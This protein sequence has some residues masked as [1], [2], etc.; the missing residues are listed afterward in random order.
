MSE[1]KG[2][3]T[4]IIVESPTKTRTLAR[5]LGKRY[6]LLATRGHV[7]DLPERRLAVNI[8]DNFRPEYEVIPRQK[9]H[10]AK[11][12]E[13]LKGVEHVYLACDPDREGEAICWHVKEV[14]GLDSERSKRIEFNE[15]TM[16]AVQQALEHPREI[17]YQRVNAQQAR[18]VLDRIVG[19]QLSPLLQQRLGGWRSARGSLSAGRVQSAALRLVVE[20]ER[21]RASFVPREYWRLRAVL[22][23]QGRKESFVAE[24][25]QRDGRKVRVENGVDAAEILADLIDAKY[26][27]VDLQTKER[28]E[29]PAPP[30][31]T[32]T[33]QRQASSRLGLSARETMSVAQRLYEGVELSEG[34][35][36]LITYMRTDSTRIAPEART[37]A[38]GF[39]RSNYGE[40]YVG[41]GVRGRAVKGAQDAHEAIRPTHVELTPDDVAPYLRP[42]ELAVY[43][44]IWRRFV[45]SQMA[46]ALWDET[47]VD[48]GAGRY[49]L[50]AKGKVLR[51]PGWRVLYGAEA[52]TEDDEK[53]RNVE[54]AAEGLLPVLSV[55]EQL[56]LLHLRAN[57]KFTEPPARYTEGTLV[58][59]LEKY[60]IGRPSTYA[61]I[62]ETLRQRR[63]VEM[64]GRYFVPTS[65]GVAVYDWLMEYFPQILDLEF[66]ARMEERLDAVERGE[67]DWVEV[68]QDF[69]NHF[70]KWLSQAEH[71]KPQ[72]LEGEVCP[73][74]HGRMLERFSR[75]GRFAGCENYPQ[76]QYTRDLGWELPEPCP[77]CGHNLE[78]VV[79]PRN[80]LQVRCGNRECDYVKDPEA[81][82][83]EEP[84]AAQENKACPECDR[85]MVLRRGRRGEQFWGCSGF[86]ECRHTE[87]LKKQGKRP[88]VETDMECPDCGKKLVVRWGRR[89][90]FL[91]CSGYP[92]CRHTRNLTDDEKRQYLPLGR[93]DEAE[94]RTG[95]SEEN[96]E[97]AE[98]D[99][100]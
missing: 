13:R 90:P 68:L 97:D 75:N 62:I 22:Q 9:E 93:S 17:N 23:P 19:Y 80:G 28:K 26:S 81:V 21:E 4:A 94:P 56:D 85:P 88:V 57:Q 7:R 69:Y 25:V 2:I 60:G 20:R 52:A 96:L 77:R 43:R 66:T 89:G 45:A 95:G 27:I 71:S 41:P 63:Y 48:V 18:R 35:T 53:E 84:P 100:G 49:V 86:P 10:L 11:L 47:I 50:Q 82:E 44:L 51:F 65:L 98:T 67:A 72:V 61:P 92:K 14:L 70:V 32:S 87:P 40:D 91:G 16:Q 99:G 30:F 31:T 38:V 12:Q 1:E 76:C 59:A 34:T 46:S 54:E 79:S 64:A 37:A 58:A 39:I 55:G 36:G 29:I 74:C 15:I 3:K 8:E 42:R 24:L 5:F 6:K 33:L 78:V 83:P 73:E